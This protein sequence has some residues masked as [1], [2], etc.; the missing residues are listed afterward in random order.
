MK[1]TYDLLEEAEAPA[2]GQLGGRFE[3]LSADQLRMITTNLHNQ[4]EGP[5]LSAHGILIWLPW[6]PCD[7]H[8]ATTMPQVLV[9]FVKKGVDVSSGE[10]T[11]AHTY[12][13]CESV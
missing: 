5:Y 11:Q 13:Q 1:G 10:H 7:L 3:V 4:D 12:L 9:K 8:I 6:H 2:A